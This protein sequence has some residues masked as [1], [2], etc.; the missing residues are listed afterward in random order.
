MTNA[1]ILRTIHFGLTL[2][3]HS[4]PPTRYIQCPVPFHPVKK[5]LM[6]FE[7]Q[8]HLDIEAIEPVPK[9]QEWAGFYSI[10]F[11]VPKSSGD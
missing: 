10:L 7:I 2:E 11:L 3:F 1:W 8:Y 4:S 5:H 9:N 6:D